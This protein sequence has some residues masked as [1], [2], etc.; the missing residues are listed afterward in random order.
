[1][2][3]PIGNRNFT[4][5]PCTEASSPT[6]P[7]D[8]QQ[9]ISTF[10]SVHERRQIQTLA[11]VNQLFE[12]NMQEHRQVACIASELKEAGVSIPLDK[13]IEFKRHVSTLAQFSPPLRTRLFHVLIA[14]P[15]SINS[16]IERA[17]CEQLLWSHIRTL[18][19]S[20]RSAAALVMVKHQRLVPYSELI[21]LIDDV[22][23]SHQ[24]ELLG[25]LAVQLSECSDAQFPGLMHALFEKAAHLSDADRPVALVH[26][27]KNTVA[28]W[29]ILP[30]CFYEAHQS[31]MRITSE[32]RT[33]SRYQQLFESAL[34]FIAEL[35]VQH[36]TMA[37]DA[38]KSP[39]AWTG[40]HGERD[41]MSRRLLAT[42]PAG[43]AAGALDPSAA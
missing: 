29:D 22:P 33:E 18:P 41:A 1:M 3:V 8:L 39:T 20:D 25:L 42:I 13:T 37:I 9:H 7:E 43:A 40:N 31:D 26:I 34:K 14:V 11:C 2:S 21:T 10:I 17:E 19:A 27:Y 12:K 30:L 36:R 15:A 28:S 4:V 16:R 38:W 6:L 35:P 23:P 32:T 24:P 5:S